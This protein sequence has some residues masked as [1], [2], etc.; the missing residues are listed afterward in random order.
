MT[1]F[2]SAVFFISS[3]SIKNSIIGFII[4]GG[5]LF[6]IA[7]VYKFF[8]KVDG[9]GGGDIKLLALI[10][11]VTGWEGALFTIFTGSLIGSLTG[12]I[13]MLYKKENLKLSIPF[14]PFFSLAA[15]L[16]IFIG[17][18]VINIYISL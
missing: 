9:I 16:Y 10:G 15:V 8:T 12:I 2:L 13:I 4:G 11:I 3:I 14:G 5:G 18:D 1:V 17:A 6:L 7:F